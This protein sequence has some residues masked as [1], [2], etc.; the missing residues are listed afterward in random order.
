MSVHTSDFRLNELKQWLGSLSA[1]PVLP[2]SIRTASADASFRRYFRV[3]AANGNSYIAMDAPPPQEDVRPFI[4]VA[5]VFAQTGASVPKVLAQDVGRGYLLL[6]DLG[7]TTYLNQLNND[8]A[9]K[10]YL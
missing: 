4:H 9:H 8:T 1:T 10:L 3:D 2:E 7:S 6:S 5:D